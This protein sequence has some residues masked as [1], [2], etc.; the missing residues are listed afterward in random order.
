[1]ILPLYVHQ[2]DASGDIAYVMAGGRESWERLHAASDLYHWGRVRQIYLLEELKSSS[3]N[4]VRGASDTRL[5]RC[6]DFLEMRGVPAEAIRSVPS[7]PNDWLGSRS[8]AEGVANLPRKFGSIVVVTSPP[9]TRRSKLCFERAFQGD[10]DI[11]VYSA[12][13][14]SGSAE[15][16]SPIWIEYAKLILYWMCA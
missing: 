10:C 12:K 13:D 3:Y 16:N 9:H 14:P 4:F 5:Q 1:M 8:E 15:T 6:I 11:L 7:R 2:R